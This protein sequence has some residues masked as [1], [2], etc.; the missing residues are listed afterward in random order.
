MGMLSRRICP[1]C[2]AEFSSG[3]QYCAY[4]AA[5]LVDAPTADSGSAR[6]S[7]RRLAARHASDPLLGT[8]IADRYRLMEVLGEGGMGVVYRAEHT[9][10]DR[11][12]AVKVLRR[13][14][15]LD[16]MARARF[17]R[18]ARAASLVCHSHVV[19]MY[20]YGHTDDGL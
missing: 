16:K 20:D 2:Q 9:V 13:E 7:K 10:L 11:P 5:P 18:E 14:L 15:T 4:D 6:E 17:D 12:F 1:T 19:T 8:V 3:E